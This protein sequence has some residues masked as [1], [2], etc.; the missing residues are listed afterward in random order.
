MALPNISENLK[1]T[2]SAE[3]KT[4]ETKQVLPS[5]SLDGTIEQII[6]GFCKPSLY[7]SQLGVANERV[8]S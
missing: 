8:G 1:E 5:L 6:G 3:Q 7:Q 2:H 4:P